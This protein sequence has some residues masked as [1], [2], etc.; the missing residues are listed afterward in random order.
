MYWTIRKESKSNFWY[1]ICIA[2]A[3]IIKGDYN[4]DADI[5]PSERFL[6]IQKASY[7]ISQMRSKDDLLVY[8]IGKN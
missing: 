8:N 7:T 5:P 1:F 6:R 4:K 3:F 2:T